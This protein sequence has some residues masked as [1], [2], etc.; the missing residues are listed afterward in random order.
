MSDT[1][2]GTPVENK[3]L[4]PNAQSDD[5]ILS[6]ARDRYKLCETADSENKA[7]MTDDLRFLAGDQW[8]EPAKRQRAIEG[9]PALTINTLPT[10]L[11]QVTNDQLQNKVSIHVHPVDDGADVQVA[12]VWEGLIRHIEYDSNAETAYDTAVN[13]AAGIGAG[14]FRIMPEYCDEKSFNQDLKILRIRN[15]LSV[16]IDPLAT[17]LDGSD[18]QYC[19]IE[20][21]MSR[22]D[23]ERQYPD[24]SAIG[25]TDF[26]SGTAWYGWMD[27]DTVL[28]CEYY[29]IAKTEATIY[30]AS[31]GNGYTKDDKLPSGVKLLSGPKEKKRK[32][33]LCKVEWFKITATDIL[34]RT[35]IMCKWIPVFPIYGDEIDILGRIFRSGIIRRAKDPS[36]AY[37]FWFTAATEEVAMRNKTPYI[38]AVGQFETQA[39]QWQDANR[40]TYATLEYD[41]ITVDG[42][43]APAPQRQ[44]MTDV[45][46]GVLMMCNHS[47]DN[48][49]A[50]T[51]LFDSSL[52]ARGNA[53]SGK[54]EIAQQRQGDTAN[55]HFTNNKN[56]TIAHAGRCLI[57]MF[58]HYYDAPR[59][60]RIMNEDGTAEQVEINQP[61][62]PE[63]RKPDPKTGVVREILNDFSTGKTARYGVAVSAG[64][65]YDTLRQESLDGMIQTA[66]A[67]PKLMDVAGDKVIAA[68]DWP[69]AT[70]IAERVKKTLPP[71]LTDDSEQSGVMVQTPQGP[72]PAEQ[73][74]QVIAQLDQATQ[75]LQEQLQKAGAQDI[76]NQAKELDIKQQEVNVKKQEADTHKTTADADLIR[77][78]A[79]A[80]AAGINIDEL[81]QAAVKDA[82]K[83]LLDTPI[84][85]LGGLVAH[86]H[87][88]PDAPDLAADAG[89]SGGAMPPP[90]GSAVAAPAPAGPLQ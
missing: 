25:I 7:L 48:I 70:E 66:R 30:L 15:A 43:L 41:P 49:K 2:S 76:A 24:A 12:E 13:S 53:T 35:E 68:M 60:L 55:Y 72:I 18:Q 64:P 71:G 26:T 10:Y 81:R 65:G 87:L 58:P 28:V 54:Q 33:S 20:Y 83:E 61:I 4:T 21:P 62:A 89:G 79:E 27:K 40:R 11:H 36:Q 84:D 63:E 19:F 67:W 34:E 59:T 85:Q 16:K 82:L 90:N 1:D 17:E 46:S 14:Y 47:R 39:D 31:D 5:E 57:D 6:E 78:S 9:R 42:T 38:G 3:S 86:P 45:P 44:P 23:F 29:R 74:G 80:A 8:P 88:S 32:T 37:N 52:G 73:A 50:T 22:V 69:G 51:G 56:V 77:A 75:Q